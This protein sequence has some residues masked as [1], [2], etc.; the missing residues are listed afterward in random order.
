[1]KIIDDENLIPDKAIL[2]KV[3]K[4]HPFYKNID[5][6]INNV[7]IMKCLNTTEN[8]DINSETGDVT[9]CIFETTFMKDNYEYILYHE[10]GHIADILNPEFNFSITKKESLNDLEKSK[11]TEIWNVYI[12][13]RLNDKNIFKLGNNDLNV[14]SMVGGKL[15]K[16]PYSIDGKLLG[17]T[18]YLKSRCIKNAKQIVEKIWNNPNNPLSYDNIIE[19]IKKVKLDIG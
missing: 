4:E 14:C 15:Q 13:S 2:E 9:L 8:I 7:I 18:H 3:I 12:D 10:I 1:M 16:L 19:I 11:V 5:K 6:I 17:H